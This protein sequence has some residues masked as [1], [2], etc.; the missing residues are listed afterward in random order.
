[1]Q[2]GSS[3]YQFQD[4]YFVVVHPFIYVVTG[5]LVIISAAA[6]ITFLKKS[7]R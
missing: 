2:L 5:T 6:I 7:S 3:N 1:M 4:S